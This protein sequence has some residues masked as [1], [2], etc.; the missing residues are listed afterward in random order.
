M[1]FGTIKG[2]ASLKIYQCSV[3]GGSGR[4]GVQT[5]FF[6]SIADEEAGSTAVIC[7]DVC[8]KKFVETPQKYY[9]PMKPR[10]YGYVKDKLKASDLEAIRRLNDGK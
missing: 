7:D 1:P 5:R 2:G 9:T 3:C 8:A 10:G 6:G 4:C